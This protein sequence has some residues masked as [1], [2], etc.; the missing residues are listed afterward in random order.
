MSLKITSINDFQV[1]KL[2]VPHVDKSRV[3]GNKL[4][5]EIYSNINL[6]ARKRSGKTNL[7]YNILKKCSDK[8]TQIHIF[9]STCLKDRAWVQIIKFLESRGNPVITHTSIVDE[10]GVNHVEQFMID[11]SANVEAPALVIQRSACWRLFDKF[12]SKLK[13]LFSTL[14]FE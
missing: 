13:I 2:R 10:D 7:I 3:K 6:V 14:F 9:C 1:G 4:F 8:N 12:L 5:D 11:N